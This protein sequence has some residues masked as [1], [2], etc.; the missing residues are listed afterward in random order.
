MIKSFLEMGFSV[1]GLHPK[2]CEGIYTNKEGFLFIKR[3]VDS[4][5][6]IKPNLGNRGGIGNRGAYFY[7]QCEGKKY[8]VFQ[9]EIEEHGLNAPAHIVR[10]KA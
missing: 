5:W 4:F 9:E 1:Q 2:N 6:P 8:K 3:G 10:S 7:F